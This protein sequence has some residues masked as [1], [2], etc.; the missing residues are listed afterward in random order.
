M[1]QK[2]FNHYD[3]Q[4]LSYDLVKEYSHVRIDK[5]EEF[6][7]RMLF[8]TFKRHTKD[9]RLEKLIDKN[10]IRMDE[11]ERI[12]TFNRLIIDANRRIEA[13]ENLESMKT[14]LD[15]QM[16]LKK[17]KQEDWDRHCC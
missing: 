12:K 7:Q 13:Q 17:Y 5:D 2:T 1:E 15:D 14:K 16:S 10:R 3:I 8:D 6:M 11:G 9:E 4:Q